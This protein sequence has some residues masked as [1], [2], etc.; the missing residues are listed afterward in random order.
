MNYVLKFD[1]FESVGLYKM[2][3]VYFLFMLVNHFQFR[4]LLLKKSSGPYP[5]YSYTYNKV[6][7]TA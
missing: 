3:W 7:I 5:W 4:Y 1:I 2:V 6:N